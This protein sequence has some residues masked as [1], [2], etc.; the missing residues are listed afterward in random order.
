MTENVRMEELGAL[1]KYTSRRYRSWLKNKFNSTR[2]NKTKIKNHESQ[3]EI[4]MWREKKSREKILE[5]SHRVRIMDENLLL[6]CTIFMYIYTIC[7]FIIY[8]RYTYMYDECYL[9]RHSTSPDVH[10]LIFWRAL[11]IFIT[12]DWNEWNEDVLNKIR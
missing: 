1:M 6:G 9:V 3:A 11:G 4:E 7:T 10:V 2:Q 8:N 5:K 12:F